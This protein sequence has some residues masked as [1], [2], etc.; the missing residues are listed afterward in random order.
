M[1]ILKGTS[2]LGASTLSYQGD[3]SDKGFKNVSQGWFDK[4]L[5]YEQGRQLLSEQK[6]KTHDIVATISEM[7]PMQDDNGHFVMRY[8]DGRMFRPTE[9][10]VGQIGNWSGAGKW[11]LYSLMNNPTNEKGVQLFSRDVGDAETV[12][13]VL[14]NGFRRVN[15][16]KPF[17]WRVREDGTLRAMLTDQYAIVNNE[18]FLDAIE[19]IIPDGRL[20]HWRGD[21]DT[22]YGN[23][24]IPDSLRKE[25]D[26]DYGGMISVGNS[27]IGERRI[28]SIPSIFRAIC[29]NG[30]IWGQEK[31][32]GIKTV[33]R[34]NIDL[35][36]LFNQIKM[37]LEAQIPLIPTGI[38]SLLRTNW[39][40]WDGLSM[41][42][43][44]AQVA[45]TYK[46]TRQQATECLEAHGIERGNNLFGIINAITRA[47]QKMDSPSWVKMDT[48][49]GSL[50][51]LDSDEWHYF[52]RSAKSLKEKQVDS[53]FT[54]A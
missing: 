1:E 50:M 18:W 49:A 44:F 37:N 28:S 41:R 53:M 51:Q 35:Q 34:G 4:T 11:F 20:S 9:H 24:L 48:V 33:H 21:A 16:E 45:M 15:P 42:P 23:V 40:G 19:K 10:A 39:L 29:M 36:K 12:V 43:I 30:C 5:S 7:T 27:E 47:G 32:V 13:K 2:N 17:L 25:Q 22:I 8:M 46:L 31:G 14:Q 38:Q 54:A 3:S 6:A 26:S 52:K